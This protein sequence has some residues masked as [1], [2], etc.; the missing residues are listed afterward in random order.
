MRGQYGVRIFKKSLVTCCK[1]VRVGLCVQGKTTIWDK[2]AKKVYGKF[3]HQLQRRM[4]T[5]WRRKRVGSVRDKVLYSLQAE[6]LLTYSNSISVSSEPSEAHCEVDNYRA[7]SV[8]NHTE[9]HCYHAVNLAD[10]VRSHW[11]NIPGEDKKSKLVDNCG[12]VGNYRSIIVTR[13]R[14]QNNSNVI[15]I[16]RPS[17]VFSYS[18]K[19]MC[20]IAHSVFYRPD[21]LPAAQ[22]TAS[23][24]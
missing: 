8:E 21:A 2:L 19:G 24:H 3:S 12:T 17:T 10:V 6:G 1:C 11:H 20:V 9:A 18:L 16:R 4:F 7:T 13:N 22:P 23:K 5:A 15:C 14:H